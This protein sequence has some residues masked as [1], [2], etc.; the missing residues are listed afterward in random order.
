MIAHG[1]LAHPND[2]YYDIMLIHNMID[3]IQSLGAFDRIVG[4]PCHDCPH[5]HAHA[6]PVEH[7]SK[8]IPSGPGEC[9]HMDVGGPMPV[10]GL[11]DELY[12]NMAKCKYLGHR[13][14]Y[15]M[16]TK[17]EIVETVR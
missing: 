9:V 4:T 17:D 7:V 14:I 8:R 1:R 5:G 11:N 13:I 16:K 10:R 2:E 12:F 6:R 15:F 3:G